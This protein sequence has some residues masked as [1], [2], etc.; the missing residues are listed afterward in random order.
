MS[1]GENL[2]KVRK[3]RGLTQEEL[4]KISG[5]GISQIRRYE[6]NKSTP[7]L[8]AIVRLVK[9]LGASIDEMVFDKATAI[10]E[11]KIIDRELLEQFEMISGMDEEE[12]KLVKKVLEG[13]I[14]RNQMEKMLKPKPEKSWA[15]RFMEITD[16]LAKG[17]KDYSQDEIDNVIDEAVAAVRE[18]RHAHS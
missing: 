11:N 8:D 18:N 2:A 13:V 1:F 15:Q 16:R 5:V 17:A 6:A 14:M 7:S 12:R 9:A 10:A 4:V 3:D